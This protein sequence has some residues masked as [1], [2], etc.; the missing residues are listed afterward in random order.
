MEK[1]KNIVIEILREAGLRLPSTVGQTLGV[2]GGI[3]IGQAVIEAK[4]R[5]NYRSWH[6]NSYIFSC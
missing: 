4:H 6:I 5:G 3:V 2:V 1:A